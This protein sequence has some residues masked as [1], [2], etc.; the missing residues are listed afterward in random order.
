M[1]IYVREKI[2]PYLKRRSPAHGGESPS[3]LVP[4]LKSTVF[5]PLA[6]PSPPHLLSRQ[7]D[8]YLQTDNINMLAT[9]IPIGHYFCVL[10]EDTAVLT[11]C[12]T[13]ELRIIYL[14]LLIR[15]LC[16]YCKYI[17]FVNHLFLY[18]FE[19]HLSLPLYLDTSRLCWFTGLCT[20]QFLLSALTPVH[21]SRSISA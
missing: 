14:T 3:S 21:F 20:R 5:M 1:F 11:V 18:S 4:C 19:I 16:I 6:L 8:I 9:P 7:Q 13:N 2:Y 10:F 12:I 15:I 17:L